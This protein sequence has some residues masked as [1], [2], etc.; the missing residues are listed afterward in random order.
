MILEPVWINSIFHCDLCKYR[1][2]NATRRNRAFRHSK[3]NFNTQHLNYSKTTWSLF[4]SRLWISHIWLSERF[5]EFW[6]EWMRI[7]HEQL[8]SSHGNLSPPTV[9]HLWERRRF[10]RTGWCWNP[11]LG[12]HLAS[13]FWEQIYR[14]YYRWFHP[15]R[16]GPSAKTSTSSLFPWNIQLK[17]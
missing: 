16:L 10:W 6:T 14:P 5:L 4:V 7:I 12:C 17:V 3:K 9:R 2:S 15:C 1:T 11:T 8:P 13:S